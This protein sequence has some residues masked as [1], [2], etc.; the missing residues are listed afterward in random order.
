LGG[1]HGAARHPATRT[2]QAL[3]MAVNAELESVSRGLEVGLALLKEGGR[4]AIIT[5]HSLEDRLVKQ[6][7]A[8]HAGRWVSL[9][10]GGERWEGKE[11][12]VT[13]VQKKPQVPSDGEVEGNPR[14]RSAKLRI[15]EKVGRFEGEKVRR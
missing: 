15:V 1:W 9:Y 3:R 13:L 8:A 4:M 6:T 5:F 14:A 2:F 11:P 10:E 7:F 12:V